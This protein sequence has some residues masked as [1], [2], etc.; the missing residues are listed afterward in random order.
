MKQKY[1]L[2]LLINKI[3][4]EA[5]GDIFDT[6]TNEWFY[7]GIIKGSYINDGNIDEIT[8]PSEILEILEQNAVK[9]YNHII[10]TKQFLTDC[11]TLCDIW[12]NI[13]KNAGVSAKIIDGNYYDGV[14]PFPMSSEHVWLEI[15]IDN[16][17]VI[18]F[19]PT[20]GQLGQ[21]D[22][23]NYWLDEERRAYYS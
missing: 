21:I 14:A 11:G 4:N 3:I 16:S 12:Q 19:D 2:N 7:I 9:V 15:N 1:I 5:I 6:A 18:I 22:I 8:I 13:L 20:A 23:R 17:Q 10:K